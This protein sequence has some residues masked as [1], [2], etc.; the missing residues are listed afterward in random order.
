M[1]WTERRKIFSE[2]I[3]TLWNKY[4]IGSERVLRKLSTENSKSETS[5]SI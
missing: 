2:E 3:L 5:S 1:V 4:K